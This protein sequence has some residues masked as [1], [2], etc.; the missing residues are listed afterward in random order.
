MILSRT[1]PVF[2]LTV[3]MFLSCS[4]AIDPKQ[5]EKIERVTIYLIGDS[6]VA[7]KDVRVYPQTGWGQVLVNH[8][9]TLTKIENRAVNGRS[10]KSYYNE[11]RW[12]PLLSKLE[13]GNYVMIQFGHNDEKV[14]IPELGASIPE[15]KQYLKT[16][17][18]ETRSK[19]AIPILITPVARRTFKNGKYIDSHGKYP[20]ATKEVSKELNVALIDLHA[21]SISLLESLGEESSRQLFL[22]VE[23][24]QY[25]GYPHGKKDNT[26]FNVQGAEAMASLVVEGLVEIKLPLINYLKKL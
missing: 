24:G 3:I 18:D 7:S 22:W 20:E 26:H 23:P 16:Y 13:K 2:L 11:K 12:E 1:L 4:S 15:F 5:S 9:D 10:A 14:D 8:F 21:K 6:T 25:Q 19:G 17:V